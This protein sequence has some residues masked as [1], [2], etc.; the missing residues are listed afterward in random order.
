VVARTIYAGGAKGPKPPNRLAARRPTTV[1]RLDHRALKSAQT[2]RSKT[3]Q[4]RDALACGDQIGALRIAARFFD[5]S[6]AT[7]IY[8]RGIKEHDHP[9]FYRQ[10]GKQPYEI[11][12][13][14]MS[15]LVERYG[16]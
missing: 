10:L 11:I 14:A 12:A 6:S 7:Q 16:D 2:M 4:V 8:K 1:A 15:A 9:D 3:Q 13:A 5:R